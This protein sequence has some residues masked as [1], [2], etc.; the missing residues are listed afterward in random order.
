MWFKLNLDLLKYL[1]FIFDTFNFGF[2]TLLYIFFAFSIL[3]SAAFQRHILTTWSLK[4]TISPFSVQCLGSSETNSVQWTW[5][6]WTDSQYPLSCRNQLK[7]QFRPWSHSLIHRMIL[8]KRTDYLPLVQ[9]WSAWCCLA[10]C[11][12]KC[13]L[14]CPLQSKT[15]WT[16]LTPIISFVCASR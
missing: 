13:R 7:F 4:T 3:G 6:L 12:Q 15:A 14:Q 16:V 9:F 5:T 2:L 1:H 10:V 8:F 11:A